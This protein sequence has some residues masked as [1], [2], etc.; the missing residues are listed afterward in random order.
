[1]LVTLDTSRG[2]PP[3]ILVAVPCAFWVETHVETHVEPHAGAIQFVSR[4]LLVVLASPLW[5]GVPEQAGVVGSDE[6][7]CV[8]WRGVQS[9]FR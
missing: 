7:S 8:G 9:R 2:T 3:L 4:R 1:M 6:T 5:C